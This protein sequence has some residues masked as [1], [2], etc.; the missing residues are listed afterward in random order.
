MIIVNVV[1]VDRT[2]VEVVAM[3]VVETE[4]V[5]CPPELPT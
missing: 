2:T 3:V 5:V 1:V 4:G